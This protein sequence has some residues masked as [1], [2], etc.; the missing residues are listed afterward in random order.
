MSPEQVEGKEADLRSDIFSLSV[1]Y[2]MVTGGKPRRVWATP[3]CENALGGCCLQ[4]RCFKARVTESTT[5]PWTPRMAHFGLQSGS[6][7]LPI[8]VQPN[9]WSFFSLAQHGSFQLATNLQT[10]RT[11][12]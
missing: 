12:G 9:L 5:S 3:L 11:P 7:I 6:G 10:C 8:Q 1:L 2:E 4:L